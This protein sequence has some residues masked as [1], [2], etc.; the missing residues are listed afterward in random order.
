M[1]R[2]RFSVEQIVGVLKQAERITPPLRAQLPGR[3]ARPNATT[4]AC[5]NSY[6]RQVVK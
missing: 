3:V 6:L 2:K 4:D 1:K 5:R